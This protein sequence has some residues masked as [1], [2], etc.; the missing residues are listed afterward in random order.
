M[1]RYFFEIQYDGRSY[2]GWQSQKNA[3]GV[4]QIVE[5]SLSTLLNTPL[6][7]V[8]SGRTDT[9]VHCAQQF[10]H[11]DIEKSFDQQTLLNK[12]N[13]FLPRDIAIAT[14]RL[15]KPDA[16]ARYS[17]I[18]RGYEYRITRKKNPF[19][20]GHS[21]HYFKPVNIQTMNKAAA[22]LLGVHDFQCFSKVKTDVNN[23]LCTIKK[24]HWVEKEDTLIFKIE[25]NRFLRGMVRAT[26]GT[27]LEVG[28]EK[29][30]IADFKQII[31]SKDRKRAG[32]NVSPSGLFLTRVKYPAS[33]FLKN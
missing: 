6:Q 32:E 15:V 1:P 24:A 23:F 31:K 18:S 30:S 21:L 13:S 33:I 16:H 3:I 2:N 12:L 20:E 19:L 5:K 8:G 4:Q 9:G 14:I 17:A 10:F 25:A 11:V 22:L 7:I 29:V 26:V 27:L 28:S